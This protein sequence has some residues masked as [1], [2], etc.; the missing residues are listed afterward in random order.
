MLKGWVLQSRL[1][2]PL[3]IHPPTAQE[4]PSPFQCGFFCVWLHTKCNILPPSTLWPTVKSSRRICRG[5]TVIRN[6]GGGGGI[7]DGIHIFIYFVKKKC[8]PQRRAVSTA[9]LQP[10]NHQI[11][12]G[13]IYQ[14]SRV[15][16]FFLPPPSIHK[17][18][19]FLVLMMRPSL[20]Y[21]S[22][23]HPFLPYGDQE[24]LINHT[25]R[26]PLFKRLFFQWKAW[27]D[28]VKYIHQFE[29]NRV[30]VAVQIS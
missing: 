22:T 3:C 28:A 16:L 9:A 1:S 2:P 17:L 7:S 29:T 27:G 12:D 23:N 13:R 4:T 5:A 10:L 6:R 19:M 25:Y 18:R 21:F 24:G 11:I 20:G 8:M 26:S 15:D 14:M 30:V